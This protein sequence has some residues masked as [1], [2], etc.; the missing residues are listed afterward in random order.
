[1][2]Y[3][4]ELV[5]SMNF[6]SK[7]KDTI[8]I[9]QS[10]T[11]PGNSMFNTLVNVPLKKK[12]EL[13]IFEDV[14]MGISIGLALKGFVPITCYPRFDFLI[15]AMNQI[16][17]HLDKIRVMSRNEMRPKVIIRTAIGAKL[18][19]DGGVQHTQDFTKIF[20]DILKE[21]IVIKLNNPSNIFKEFSKAYNNRENKSYLFIEDGDHY[22]KK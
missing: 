15:L 10:V 21:I 2:S 19:L 12:I 4:T 22:N 8:F 1:M 14:Q 7:K 16:V 6:L 3:K 13:P 11:Y 9:G 18:P 20:K 17:N 5:K